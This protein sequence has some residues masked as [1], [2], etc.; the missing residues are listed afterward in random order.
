MLTAEKSRM[1][2][3]HKTAIQLTVTAFTLILLF[4]VFSFAGNEQRAG[5]AGAG[6]LLINPWARSTGWG[7]ANTA[8]AQGLEAIFLN[9]AGTAFTPHTELIFAHTTWLTNSGVALNSFGFSQKM[10]EAGVLSLAVMTVDFGEINVTTVDLPEGGIGT[11]HPQYTN[12]SLAYA[13]EFSNSIYGGLTIKILSEKTS[14]TAA[15]GV[16]LDAGIQYVTGSD[17]QIR[18]GITMKNVGPT[19][20]FSGDGLSFRGDVPLTGVSLTV[21]QR[22]AEYELPSLIMIGGSYDFNISE[23]HKLT[24]AA[25]FTS[26]SFTNDQYHIGLQYAYNDILFLRGGYVYEKGINSTDER[27]TVFTGPTAGIS[28]QVPLNTEKGSVFSIDY[29]Y[30]ATNPFSGVHSIGARVSL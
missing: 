13:K 19:M 10:G 5:Q 12:I 30:R 26:N 2:S 4:P 23:R 28:I 27:T 20:K 25:N 14:N 1:F 16:A 24:L 11:F 29:S 17:R 22:S 6:E 15:S 8:Y 18:F 7:G 21:E 9:V 3:W